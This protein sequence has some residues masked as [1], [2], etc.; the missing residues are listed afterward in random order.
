MAGKVTRVLIGH[1]GETMR[2]CEAGTRGFCPREN[3]SRFFALSG[4]RL[5]IFSSFF[6]SFLLFFLLSPRRFCPRLKKPRSTAYYIT[7]CASPTSAWFHDP[8]SLGSPAVCFSPRLSARG[9]FSPRR[10]AEILR[11]RARCWNNDKTIWKTWG[12]CSPSRSGCPGLTWPR[13]EV[14]PEDS[15]PRRAQ[16]RYVASVL[17]TAAFP[18]SLT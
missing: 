3:S 1:E 11:G 15:S 4:G 13:P 16:S 17:R 8:F 18:W 5:V 12:E 2:G 10:S 9:Y 6:H 14:G 7:E